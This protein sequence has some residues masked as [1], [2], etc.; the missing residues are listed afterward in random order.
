MK[1]IE[2]S[3]D[4]SLLAEVDSATQSLD[5]TRSDFVNAALRLALHRKHSMS[6]EKLHA[7]G[8]ADL[9]QSMEEA[10]EWQSEQVWGAL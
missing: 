9:P 2:L 10:T 4:D 5:M 6:L 7:K 1:T 3:L 8:Y